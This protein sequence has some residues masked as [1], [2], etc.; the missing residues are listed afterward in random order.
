MSKTLFVILLAVS[1]V[2]NDTCYQNHYARITD[3]AINSKATTPHGVHVD[4]SGFTVDLE[5]IDYIFDSVEQCLLDNFEK[6]APFCEEKKTYCREIIDPQLSEYWKCYD[7]MVGCQNYQRVKN[8]LDRSC[9]K[10]KIAPDWHLSCDDRYMLF[11][12]NIPIQGCLDKGL[13]PTPEC[14][15]SC[16]STIQGS[17]IITT[18]ELVVLSGELVRLITGFNNPWA[19]EPLKACPNF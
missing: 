2:A 9:V 1:C 15:C 11:P 17:D 16:R 7:L 19:V 10:I 3:Y 6:I 4:T 18:P 8:G 14:P 5:K 12:C 13:T